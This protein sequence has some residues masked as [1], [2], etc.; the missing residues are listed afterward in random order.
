MLKM[1]Y[2]FYLRMHRPQSNKSQSSK[3]YFKRYRQKN[4]DAPKKKGR[5][6]KK[7]SREYQKYVCPQK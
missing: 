2:F 1:T 6:R 3:D 7:A 4:K 5:E